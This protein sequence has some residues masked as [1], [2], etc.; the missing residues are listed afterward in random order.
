MP[1]TPQLM[2][3]PVAVLACAA[4]LLLADEKRFAGNGGRIEAVGARR[5]AVPEPEGVRGYTAH[6]VRSSIPCHTWL[7]CGAGPTTPI[8][9]VHAGVFLLHIRNVIPRLLACT[10]HLAILLLCPLDLYPKPVH[11]WNK[12]WATVQDLYFLDSGEGLS[13]DPGPLVQTL[14]KP[15]PRYTGALCP[16][17]L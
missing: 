14:N 8:I 15:I 1:V 17:E 6:R 4:V 12:Q 3:R 9:Q 2:G 16:T 5:T 10:R 7:G 11:K 13:G